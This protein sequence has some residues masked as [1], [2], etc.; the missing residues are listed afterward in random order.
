MS[1]IDGASKGSPV[2]GAAFSIGDVVQKLA[3]RREY[4]FI[5][6]GGLAS[7][8]NWISRFPLALVLSFE[9][10]VALAYAVGMGVGFVLYRS[11]VF[12]ASRGRLR[13]QLPRFVLVNGF[14]LAAVMSSACAFLSLLT[15]V[16]WLPGG[17]TQAIAHSLALVVGAA[18]NFLG[19]RSLTFG[20]RPVEGGAIASN[21]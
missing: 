14:G 19:H 15:Q 12:D 17:W 11:W 16:S 8:V 20:G 13:D 3:G 18:V 4:K 21:T 2:L 5:V 10:A 1:S 9:T 6:A 7:A